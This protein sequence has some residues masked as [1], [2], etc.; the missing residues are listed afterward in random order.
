MVDIVKFLYIKVEVV[1]EFIL[2]Y[3]LS[4]L[5]CFLWRMKDD[6]NFFK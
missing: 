2:L 5:V 3:E 1:I 4:Y 6:Y